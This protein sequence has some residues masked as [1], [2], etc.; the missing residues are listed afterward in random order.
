MFGMKTESEQNIQDLLLKQLC[1]E[2]MAET[3]GPSGYHSFSRSAYDRVRSDTSIWNG[4]AY[5]DY[6]GLAYSV[7]SGIR[8]GLLGF[9]HWT[10]DTGGYVRDDDE[11]T[12]DLWARWMQFSVFSVEYELMLGTNHTPWYPPYSSDLVSILKQT[13][14]LHHELIPYIKSY[15]YQSTITGIPVMR[16]LFLEHPRDKHTYN[17]SDAYFFGEHFLVAPVVDES[18]KREVYFPKGTDYLEYFDKTSVHEGGSAAAV[19]PG[20]DSIPVYVKAGA[21]VPRG[22]IVQAN[23][24]WTKDWSPRLTVELFPSFGV[25][26]SSFAYYNGNKESEIRMTSTS[27]DDGA[28]VHVQYGELGVGGKI[29]VYTQNGPVESDLQPKGGKAEFCDIESLF[30]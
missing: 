2:N 13:A 11:P 20:L 9:S 3:W 5:A 27:K 12:E 1:G 25:P 4:D 22:D 18:G 29:V 19:S 10:S 17:I 6:T 23:N 21:I 30:G 16:A 26:E 24:K 28:C 8:S 7:A 15:S 14:N